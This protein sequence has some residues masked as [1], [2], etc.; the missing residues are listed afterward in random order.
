MDNRRPG[1]PAA[2]PTDR[3]KPSRERVPTTNR[4]ET[5]RSA[6]QEEDFLDL[7]QENGKCS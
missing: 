5:S 1:A 7:E 4:G 6:Q 3:N 2:A